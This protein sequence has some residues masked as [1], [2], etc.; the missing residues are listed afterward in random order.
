[1]EG[2]HLIPSLSTVLSPGLDPLPAISGSPSHAWAPSFASPPPSRARRGRDQNHQ[3]LRVPPHSQPWQAALFQKTR[4]LCGAT[5][6]APRWLLT[7]AHCR[8]CSE[9]GAG[10]GGGWRWR[11]GWRGA[12]GQGGRGSGGAGGVRDDG[13]RRRKGFR[14][15]GMALGS[16]SD[17]VLRIRS[18]D[19]GEVG[20]GA[21]LP[22]SLRPSPHP[23]ALSISCV[24]P[25]P[26][27]SDRCVS[28]TSA[29]TWFAWERTA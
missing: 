8:S 25:S 2:F 20:G 28:P 21:A 15:P 27:I 24:S 17:V 4:L 13:G 10:R 19:G 1:M 16:G 29:D 18:G 5:L 14:K 12:R 6:I 22:H 26:S 23:H 3:G 9:R 11:D 7:V